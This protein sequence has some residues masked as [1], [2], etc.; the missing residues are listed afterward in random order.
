[1]SQL[2]PHFLARLELGLDADSKSIRRAYA[3]E[4][5]L[6]DQENDLSGFQMLR[7]AYEAALEWARHGG[8]QAAPAWPAQQPQPEKV[9]APSQPAAV[10]Q[11]GEP[12]QAPPPP[13]AA[14]PQQKPAIPLAIPIADPHALAETVFARFTVNIKR[15]VDLGLL[16]DPSLLEA[17]IRHRLA[18]DELLNISARS[19]FEAR[20][21]RLLLGDW[22]LEAGLLFG[23]AALVFGWE[24][25]RRR[26][27]QFGHAGAFLDRAIDERTMFEAQN[28]VELTMQ[29]NVMARLRQ[30]QR[31]AIVQIRRDMVYLERMVARFPS[32]L[33]IM[34]SRDT[35]EQWRTLALKPAPAQAAAV[36]DTM[37]EPVLAGHSNRRRF[38]GAWLFFALLAALYVGMIIFGRNTPS[39][40]EPSEQASQYPSYAPGAD[41][42]APDYVPPLPGAASSYPS[43][44][45]GAD[46]SAPDYSPLPDQRQLTPPALQAARDPV[47]QRVLAAISADIEYKPAGGAPS[48]LRAVEFEVLAGANGKIF[49]TSILKRSIDPV[50]DEA[51]EAAIMRAKPLPR[52]FGT[53]VRMR[54]SQK[55]TKKPAR[56]KAPAVK[57]N[58][59]D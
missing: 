55:W 4:L 6:V 31:P 42:S 16:K 27:Q 46:P 39:S 48:G 25:D 49:G 17:E 23:A 24:K 9:A 18:D 38:D 45:P 10:P 44:A 12:V 53:R 35:V 8:A 20:V 30:P 59:V 21:A 11:A 41:P 43:Y 34:V 1:M 2:A 57:E 51:V 15:I 40:P 50:F 32:F 13:P 29:R 54:F 3:R 26:L 33:A 19:L 28:M 14:A 7:E 37:P 22:T 47:D 36:A 56:R 58:P 52:N 5:K